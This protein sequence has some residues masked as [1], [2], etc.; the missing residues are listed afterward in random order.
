M[1]LTLA[2]LLAAATAAS[3]HAQ[4]PKVAPRTVTA[5]AAAFLGDIRE[6]RPDGKKEVLIESRSRKWYRARLNKPCAG[7]NGD[8]AFG[9]VMEPEDRLDRFKSIVVNGQICGVA[10]LELIGKPGTAENPM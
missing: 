4:E 9:F 6:W 10:S 1:K 8:K 2:V 3:L 7:I 5:Q